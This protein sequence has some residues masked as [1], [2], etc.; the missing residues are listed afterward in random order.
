VRF[1]T[2]DDVMAY[3]RRFTDYERM[4]GVRYGG[5]TYNLNRMRRLC[6]ALGHP[7]GGTP[8]VHV[9]GTKGKGSV[10]H[11]TEAILRAHGKRT[12]LYVSPHLVDLLERIQVDGT[13]VS[14]AEFVRTINAMAPALAKLRPTFFEIMT[15]AAFMIFRR[16]KV[17]RAVYEVGLGGRLDATNVVWP[18]ACAIT[19]IDY[20]HMDKLGRTLGA[21][22]SEKAGI[23]KPGIRTVVG[24]MRPAA[25]RVVVARARELAAP[26][27]EPSR[28]VPARLGAPG[29]H[30]RENAA[31]A[32]ALASQV[33]KLDT[34]RVANA[35]AS[36]RIP[37]RVETVRPG[38]VVDVAH[39]PVAMRATVAAL[40]KA[41][42]RIV[43]F[44]SS[45][46]KNWRAMLGI[47]R[48]DALILTR[49][50]NPRACPPSEMAKAAR[51]AITIGSVARAVALARK[52]AGKRDLVVVT[53]SF[54]V[55]GEALEALR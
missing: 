37:G 43:V 33:A 25:R 28:G 45:R 21:I 41:R 36:L 15:A 30:Q 38:V 26:V 23:I 40:P 39:N 8:C 16:R 52:M 44:G 29:A 17:E 3:L 18:M 34:R 46:D 55:A 31:V 9:A 2:F 13:P 50:D 4:T 11:M 27:V 1:K 12:G 7:E 19:R 14:R 47:L 48:A 54:Y 35:L 22:A 51:G 42:R 5:R 20:D 32:I 6:A 49:A 53:G 10:A 24:A